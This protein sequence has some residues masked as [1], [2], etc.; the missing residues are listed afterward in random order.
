MKRS[1]VCKLA[2]WK[3]ALAI[4]VALAGVS[5]SSAEQADEPIIGTWKLNLA[6]SKYIPGPPPR[7]ETRVY[8]QTA[9]GIL[10]TIDRV[11]ATGQKRQKIEF[12]ERYDGKDYPTV[13]SEISD[14][15]ALK[16]I[17]DYMSESVLK[18]GGKVVATARRIITDGGKTLMLIYQET[19]LEHPVDNIIVYDRQ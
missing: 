5:G 2:G 14:A 6:K 12:P 1:L 19:S 16:R 15:I 13:G 17:N 18:H 8:R 9:D 11:D 10:V 7:S 4:L 3:L